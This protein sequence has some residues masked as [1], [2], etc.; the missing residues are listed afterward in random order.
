MFYLRI[1]RGEQ[2]RS[3]R[4]TRALSVPKCPYS[5]G[6]P[7]LESP[8]PSHPAPSLSSRGGQTP[9]WEPR[10]HSQAS[11]VLDVSLLW[12]LLIW[13]SCRPLPHTHDALTPFHLLLLTKRRTWQGFVYL[14]LIT[15]E[16]NCYFSICQAAEGKDVKPRICVNVKSS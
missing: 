7:F 11:I 2:G 14:T 3:L 8:T 10:T 13:L 1:E 6:L 12:S 5:L 4:D 9:A 15:H 16:T